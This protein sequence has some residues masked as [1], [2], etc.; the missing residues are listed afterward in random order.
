M[1][2]IVLSSDAMTGYTSAKV[3]FP[4]TLHLTYLWT[5]VNVYIDVYNIYWK[6][7]NSNLEI[8]VLFMYD[9]RSHFR[10]LIV[11]SDSTKLFPDD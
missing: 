10:D 5:C 9:V 3:E 8:S 11:G 4:S 7:S 2:S 6:E 1:A